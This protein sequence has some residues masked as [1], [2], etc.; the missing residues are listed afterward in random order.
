MSTAKEPRS[1][2]PLFRVE[3]HYGNDVYTVVP[4]APDLESLK[5]FRLR[6]QT[7]DQQVYMICLTHQGL[8]CNCKGFRYRSR[9][10]H[11]TMFREAQMFDEP[12]R[13]ER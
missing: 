1:I 8:R 10:K 9:C 5:A 7:G 3:F 6:K 4:L 13:D 2:I 12:G 11:V